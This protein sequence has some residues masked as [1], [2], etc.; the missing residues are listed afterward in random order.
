MAA[1]A[2][3]SGASLRDRVG[4]SHPVR[5]DEGRRNTVYNAI[6][7][8]GA[9]YLANFM[10]LGVSRY[11]VEFL[12]ESADKVR[13]VLSLYER[14]LKGEISGTQV[15]KT[16]KATNQLGVTRGQLVK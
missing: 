13:E 15:W 2:R 12:E 14:A 11:R 5:V 10:E 8:S 16:L 7:Q 9:E 1:H 4:F 3:S 6:D